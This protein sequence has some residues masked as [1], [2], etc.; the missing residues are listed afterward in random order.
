MTGNEALLAGV[1]ARADRQLAG[2]RVGLASQ[3][4]QARGM[5]AGGLDETDVWA[6]LATRIATELDCTGKYQQFAV[7]MLAAA[8]IRIAGREPAAHAP[9]R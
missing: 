5:L 1:R 9:A 3:V 7:E 6:V 8:A 2:V 4:E